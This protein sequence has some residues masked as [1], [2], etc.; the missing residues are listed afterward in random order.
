MW[1]RVRFMN[2]VLQFLKLPFTSWTRYRFLFSILLPNALHLRSLTTVQRLSLT[3]SWN[4]GY[5]CSNEVTLTS[6]G[7]DKLFCSLHL[8]GGLPFRRTC[9]V[10]WSPPP[11]PRRTA[12]GCARLITLKKQPLVE[13][14][15]SFWPM[16]LATPSQPEGQCTARTHTTRMTSRRHAGFK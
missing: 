2:L 16:S 12:Q 15:N 14:D 13:T 11:A 6:H 4:K 10:Y 7:A 8:R 3:S 5:N 9:A 1:W